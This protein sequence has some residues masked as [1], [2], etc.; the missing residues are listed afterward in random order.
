MNAACRQALLD[1]ARPDC[2]LAIV[3]AFN[4][5][6]GWLGF[7]DHHGVGR[8]YRERVASFGGIDAAIRMFRWA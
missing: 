5:L 3:C 2:R 8:T 6:D 1:A 4:E 7:V